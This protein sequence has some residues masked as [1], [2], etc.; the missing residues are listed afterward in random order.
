MSIFTTAD[1]PVIT[2]M[3]NARTEQRAID[4]IRMSM[5]QGA[6]AFGIQMDRML[7]SERTKDTV[8]HL[9]DACEGKPLYLTNYAGDQNKGLSYEQLAQELIEAADD[10]AALI[11]IPADFYRSMPHQV[12][13]QEDVV[14]R[15]IELIRQIHQHGAEVL[16]SSHTYCFL[17]TQEVMKIAEAH[18]YRGADISKIVIWANSEEELY[19]NMATELELRRSFRMRHLFLSANTMARP[20]RVIG[21]LMGSCMYLTIYEKDDVAAQCQPLL[22]DA[23]QILNAAG[24][25]L[26]SHS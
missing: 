8:K 13:Y 11:D 20:H 5:D 3:V 15:Q 10:G 25:S 16:M 14:D 6:D 1:K 19:M 24:M 22:R 23:F 12:A 17:N 26:S 21:P 7:R 4:L 2:V 9:V 18:R